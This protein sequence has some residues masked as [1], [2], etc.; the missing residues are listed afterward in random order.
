MTR[1]SLGGAL[2]LAASCSGGQ[3]KPILVPTIRAQLVYTPPATDRTVYFANTVVVGDVIQMDVMI[4][5]FSNTLDI[6]DVDLV[7]E[8]DASFVQIASLNGQNT[9]FGTCNTVNPA[10]GVISPICVNNR[11]VANGGSPK[12]CKSNSATTCTLDKDCPAGDTCV[13]LGT[14]QASFAVLTGPKVCSS[15]ASR[16][17]TTNSQ[18]A[19][20]KQNLAITC[21]G[22]ADCAGTCSAGT[23]SNIPGRVCGSDSDCQDLCDLTATCR[24]CPSVLV[25]GVQK[26][27]SLAL[28]VMKAGSGDFRFVVSGG[29]RSAVRKD[30][31]DLGVS[32]F[33]QVGGGSTDIVIIGT[34]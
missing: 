19:F 29:T 6:D 17:C 23:C 18:C 34:L 11:I 25:G 16:T 24:G 15:D 20:C 10:C 30:L 5:D 1:A 31:T 4:Q 8:Y 26:I 28:R 13:S 2:L 14:L 9:I 7:I 22:N 33:P 32:F 27:A 12:T 3:E 21:S